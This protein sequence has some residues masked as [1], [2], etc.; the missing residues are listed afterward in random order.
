MSSVQPALAPDQEYLDPSIEDI[1]RVIASQ[2]TAGPG[3]RQQLDDGSGLPMAHT[4]DAD[5]TLSDTTF[6]AALPHLPTD[7]QDDWA[8]EQLPYAKM[9]TVRCR[10]VVSQAA[11][12]SER[13]R[14]IRWCFGVVQAKGRLHATFEDCCEV[15]NVRKYV[16]QAMIQHQWFRHGIVLDEELPFTCI[17][18]EPVLEEARSDSFDVGEAAMRAVWLYPSRTIT[19]VIDQVAHGRITRDMCDVGLASMVEK[20]RLGLRD[21]RLWF[22]GRSPVLMAK[23]RA[24]FSRTYQDPDNDMVRRD[25]GDHL[26]YGESN[27][28]FGSE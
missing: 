24:S 21:G 23:R 10:R 12:I 17:V 25:P 19:R 28:L 6:R 13:K 4:S 14:L 9:M 1:E 22:T 11:G 15:L 26:S 7:W 8:D 16:M 18:P 2:R 20:G 3:R 5:R 27:A